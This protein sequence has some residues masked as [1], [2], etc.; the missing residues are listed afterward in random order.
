MT[1]LLMVILFV[2]YFCAFKYLD[3]VEGPSGLYLAALI[4]L[5][6]YYRSLV[7]YCIC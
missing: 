5:D 3:Y 1:Y 6:R 7:D 4:D 2:L